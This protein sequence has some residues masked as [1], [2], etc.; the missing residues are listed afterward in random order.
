MKLTV[1]SPDGR[2]ALVGFYDGGNLIGENCLA[3]GKHISNHNAVALT[4]LRLLK[5]DC[6]VVTSRMAAEAR[7]ACDVV[8]Y[9][10]G[11][12]AYIQQEL[13]DQLLC[14]SEERL[15]R[16]LFS[17]S[18]SIRAEHRGDPPRLTQQDL[19]NMLGTTRQRVNALVA[20]LKNSSV[21]QGRNARR[22]AAAKM[23][24]AALE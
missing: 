5:F 18:Q 23:A 10:L 4:D 1:V 3:G 11:R 8:T 21:A 12:N 6:D 19:A 13:A 7:I 15:A 14:S 17:L 9:L 22:R 16:I 24:V 20:R 2:E